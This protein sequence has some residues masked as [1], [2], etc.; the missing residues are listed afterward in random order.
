MND[1]DDDEA[2]RSAGIF[3]VDPDTDHPPWFAPVG[4]N[5]KNL[6]RTIRLLKLSEIYGEF[7][8][9]MW[10]GKIEKMD[11]ILEAIIPKDL[12]LTIVIGYLTASLPVKDKLKSRSALFKR[13]KEYADSI[14]RTE[15]G[16]LDGLE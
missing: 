5:R 3:V 9:M 14:G 2:L 15:P 13:V 16:L 12:P 1:D 10:E 11:K 4:L 8:D 6:G 7:N